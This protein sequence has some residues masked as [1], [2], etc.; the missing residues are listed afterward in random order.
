M[1]KGCDSKFVRDVKIKLQIY[2]EIKEVF[3]AE[4]IHRHCS[5]FH[6]MIIGMISS[7][8][9]K[10]SLDELNIW[11]EAY[12]GRSLSSGLAFVIKAVLE[13]GVE[14]LGE[15]SNFEFEIALPYEESPLNEQVIALSA[16][17]AGLLRLQKNVG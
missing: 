3:E 14:S 17:C 1:F 6:G 13:Q 12:L 8:G 9:Q 11:L 4:S 16:W 7:K 15:Y 5:E 2:Q 10:F